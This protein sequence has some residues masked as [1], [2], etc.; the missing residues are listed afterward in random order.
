M[1]T[2]KSLVIILMFSML[3][4]SC[5]KEND[6]GSLSV[7]MTDFPADYQQVNVEIL[8]VRVHLSG[9]G[10]SGQW[11]DLPTKKGVYDLLTLQ[12]GIDTTIVNT[13]ELPAGKISQ[14]RLLLGSN[15][16]IM[17]N[18]T[19]YNMTVPSGNETGIKLV[20]N[21]IVPANS[22]VNV[23]LDFVA[24]ESVVESGNGSYHLKPVLKVLN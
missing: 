6:T 11:I 19:L 3:I 5:K 13:I 9:P 16:S 2:I 20:G 10:G 1:K 12:N 17:V 23:L 18:D 14:M 7:R 8:K 15:N 24:N 21:I 4:T 22:T